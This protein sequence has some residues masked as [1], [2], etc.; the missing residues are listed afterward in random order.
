[1]NHEHSQ[2][3]GA[4]EGATFLLKNWNRKSVAAVVMCT[5]VLT[6]LLSSYQVTSWFNMSM[7]EHDKDTHTHTHTHTHT[8]THTHARMHTH[9]THTHTHTHTF[10]AC[11]YK[12]IPIYKYTVHHKYQG[13]FMF[14]QDWSHLKQLSK[15]CLSIGDA[16]KQ[17][18]P[19]L[20]IE[21]LT[22][23]FFCPI[24]IAESRKTISLL[25]FG[26]F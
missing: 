18:S 19:F 17:K 4:G 20:H 7:A 14:K 6:Y 3:K 11:R 10:H 21:L 26:S 8:Y 2:W 9:T 13:A 5:I 15:I 23:K 16:L 12:T 22:H 1:M 24:A 25:K